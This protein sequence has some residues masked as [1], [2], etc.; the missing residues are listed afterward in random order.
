[1]NKNMGKRKKKS[2]RLYYFRQWDYLRKGHPLLN[3]TP[4]NWSWLF[5]S[6]TF[7]VSS[8]FSRESSPTLFNF[9]FKTFFRFSNC[10]TSNSGVYGSSSRSPCLGRSLTN[11]V[12]MSIRESV[13]TI[14]IICR[15]RVIGD[16]TELKQILIYLF[17]R[18][19][20]Q[21]TLVSA[22][23]QTDTLLIQ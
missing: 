12:L 3:S 18:V 23:F 11:Q 15:L 17:E 22:I 5:V 20:C 8:C 21:H 9:K 4:F 10:R 7:R 16:L 2:I 19:T 14:L 13:Q 6:F 1:M